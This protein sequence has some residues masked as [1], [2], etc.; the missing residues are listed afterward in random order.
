MGL[1]EVV[2][3]GHRIDLPGWTMVARVSAD[4]TVGRLTVIERRMIAQLAGPP[5]HVHD[6]RDETFVVLVGRMS[7]AEWN[8]VGDP[9]WTVCG[10]SDSVLGSR[11]SCLGERAGA[12]RRRAEASACSP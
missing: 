11:P 5:A 4:D 2:R 3:D 12:G 10:V 9:T 8:L 7:Q 6:G 1:S